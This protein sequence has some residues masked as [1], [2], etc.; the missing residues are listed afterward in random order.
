MVRGGEGTARLRYGPVPGVSSI[1]GARQKAR[2][3][4]AQIPV[5]RFVATGLPMACRLPYQVGQFRFRKV[6]GSPNRT[7]HAPIS[8]PDADGLA[9]PFAASGVPAAA[10][11][12]SASERSE[13]EAWFGG[14]PSARRAAVGDQH[15]H[16]GRPGALEREPRAGADAGLDHQALH[17]RILPDPDGRRRALHYPRDRR[18]PAGYGQRHLGRDLGAGAG[19]RPDA[20]PRRP[21]RAPRCA[22]WPASCASAASACSRAPSPSPAGPVPPRRAIPRC[23]P[24]T[25]RASSTRPPV[26]PVAAPR[27][28]GLADLPPGPRVRRAAAAGERLSG[29]CRAAWFASRPRRW[30][31][32]SAGSRS[33]PI[34]TA[35]GRCAAR[36]GIDRPSAGLSAVA[37]DPRSCSSPPGRQRSSARASAG[38]G[39]G[40]P[41][42]LA[43]RPATILAQVAS[44]PLDS[45]ATEVNRRSLNIGAELMLQFAAGN[46]LT[47][48]GLLTQ[49]VR[50][51]RRPR[52]AGPP[53]GR[54][55]AQRVQPD[56]LADPDA[57]PRPLSAAPRQP[58]LPAAAARQR[59]RHAAPAPRRRHGAGRGARQDRHARRSGDPRRLS[60]AARTG[61]W[62][63]R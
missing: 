35:A 44:A 6:V 11:E 19:R 60:R 9:L 33:A 31:A 61:C 26:G 59:H 39:P 55:R 15:R 30:T 43:P 27:E 62:C 50:A 53:G 1:H 16:H 5:P 45:I 52:R 24:P 58:A 38:C 32:A 51:G 41:V 28:H 36:I 7:L 8:A 23:G 63:C 18:R 12:L 2:P 40:G 54:Q 42:L 14:P 21:A 17:H 49:H 10:Q 3:R 13:L 37:H 34:R 29:R 56:E 46:Q 20:R 57:L 22:S 47:G 4:A 25:S 48:P